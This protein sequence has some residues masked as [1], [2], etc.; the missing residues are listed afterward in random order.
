MV[1][2]AI[3]APAPSLVMGIAGQQGVSE[4]PLMASVLQTSS[5]DMQ[6]LSGVSGE[7]IAA[8]ASRLASITDAAEKLQVSSVAWD[9]LSAG[10][11][12]ALTTT[13]GQ[14]LSFR[15]LGTRPG[16]AAAALNGSPSIDLAITP[17]SQSGE[18]VA[19]AVIESK[20]EI[21]G[22]EPE[23]QRSL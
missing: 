2:Y 13:S 18:A 6:I 4:Y 8:K 20:S 12:I 17:C 1:F 22:K 23:V 5:Q 21:P 16:P 14:N 19:K 10:D 11:C 7:A 9:R 3:A 15:I